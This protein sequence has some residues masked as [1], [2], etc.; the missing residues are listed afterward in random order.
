MP[1]GTKKPNAAAL[2]WEVRESNSVYRGETFKLLV[3][4]LS[5]RDGSEMEYA[6][7]ERREAVIVVPVT[8]DGQIVTI[9][10]Y[11][12]PVDDWCVE[13]PVGRTPDTGDESLHEV[14]RKELREKIGATY[15]AVTYLGAFYSGPSLTDEKCHVFL[16]ENVDVTRPSEAEKTEEIEVN[17]IETDEIIEMARSGKMKNGVCSL[18]VLWCER[19]LHERGYI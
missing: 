8:R 6:Y 16:A 3:D 17:L 9:R 4:R 19:L 14:V 13:V 1:N 7:V 15:G 10:Q 18:A 12:Y 5:L 2:R 11:R